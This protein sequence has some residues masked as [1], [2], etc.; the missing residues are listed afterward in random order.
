MGQI[1]TK[2]ESRKVEVKDVD[3][4]FTFKTVEEE[5]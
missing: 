5:K 4:D 1:S 3:R 2:K